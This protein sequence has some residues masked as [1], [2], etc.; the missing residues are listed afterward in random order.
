MTNFDRIKKMNEAKMAL[1]LGSVIDCDC[2]PK[3]D[4]CNHGSTCEDILFRWL[5]EEIG[6]SFEELSYGQKFRVKPKDANIYIKIEEILD[7]NDLFWNA[8]NLK[9]G[10]P[11]LFSEDKLVFEE[12]IAEIDN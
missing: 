9:T 7:N 6:V 4:S 1:A 2:C 10:V 8:I 5:K 11:V 3:K 12:K